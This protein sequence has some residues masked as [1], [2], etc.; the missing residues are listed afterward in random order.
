M[1]PLPHEACQCILPSAHCTYIG[2]DEY[3]LEKVLA[4]VR[5]RR[6]A[7]VGGTKQVGHLVVLVTTVSNYKSRL[8]TVEVGNAAQHAAQCSSLT[9]TASPR[10]GPDVVSRARTLSPGS[11]A[12]AVT[13]ADTGRPCV[14]A[15][16]SAASCSKS[17]RVSRGCEATAGGSCNWACSTLTA[18]CAAAA[19]LPGASSIAGGDASGAASR[20]SSAARCRAASMGAS[21]SSAGCGSMMLCV[22]GR[23]HVVVVVVHKSTYIPLQARN[24]GLV[25]CNSRVGV[26]H[27]F[28]VVQPVPQECVGWAAYCSTYA[29]R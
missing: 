5:N 9:A 19:S 10:S 24:V 26:M 18:A 17:S 4:D 14:S 21:R 27:E 6:I 16:S 13:C 1:P 7:T 22:Q 23:L 12:C 25:S 28:G 2:A 29:Y 15:S 8:Y 11:C 20:H 3:Q